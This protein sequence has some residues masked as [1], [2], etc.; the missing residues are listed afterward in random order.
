MLLGAAD[1]GSKEVVVAV[2]GV[3]RAVGGVVVDER[4]PGIPRA[5]VVEVGVGLPGV[6]P[7]VA[8][9]VLVRFRTIAAQGQQTLDAAL[10]VGT[11]A[12]DDGAAGGELGAEARGVEGKGFVLADGDVAHFRVGV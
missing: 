5:V 11:L 9:L 3:K 7:P 2:G 12:D 6:E 8:V 1:E 10:A 4:L